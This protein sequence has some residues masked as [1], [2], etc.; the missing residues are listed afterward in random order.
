MCVPCSKVVLVTVA[1]DLL[2]FDTINANMAMVLDEPP[3]D[4]SKVIPTD[5]VLMTFE[6][7]R[8]TPLVSDTVTLSQQQTSSQSSQSQ[9]Q[10]AS[11]DQSSAELF[12]L[13]S[14]E[15]R[16][17]AIKVSAGK[18][19][20]LDVFLKF[21]EKSIDQNYTLAK[22]FESCSRTAKLNTF[23]TLQSTNEAALDSLIVNKSDHHLVW[24]EF[25]DKGLM[26]KGQ[27][28]V[29]PPDVKEIAKFYNTTWSPQLQVCIK[30]ILSDTY[31]I[32]SIK[33]LG[34][35]FLILELKVLFL[36]RL[37]L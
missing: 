9:T 13:S 20:K 34:A 11:Q 21:C 12:E 3:E 2:F 6:T 5:D 10:S 36:L 25:V 24:K 32:S 4:S 17:E 1:F 35:N 28:I 19:E 31:R 8:D 22:D 15:A 37:R 23:K 7:V 26:D 18:K 27:P 33:A 16:D 14:Q 30:E 29:Q